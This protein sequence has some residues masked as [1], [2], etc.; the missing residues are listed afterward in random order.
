VSI[1][2]VVKALRDQY[3]GEVVT[4]QTQILEGQS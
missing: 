1:G 2:D 3:E 4:L